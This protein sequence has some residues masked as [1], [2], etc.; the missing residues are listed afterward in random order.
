MTHDEFL[1][2]LENTKRA[3]NGHVA[4]CP[5]HEDRKQSLGV[6]QGDDGRV[7]LRCYA[8]C[9][10]EQVVT[11]MGLELKDLF[12]RPAGLGDPEAIYD[13]VDESGELVM[14]AIRFP[15]KNFRQRQ[16]IPGHAHAD[17]N[18]WVWSLGNEEKGIPFVQRVPYRLPELLE[19]IAAGRWVFITEGEKDADAII[20][21]GGAAT[22]NPGGAGKWPIEWGERYFKGANVRIVVDRDEAG[23]AGA[24]VVWG[25]LEPHA[26]RLQSVAA[27]AGKDAYDHLRAGHELGDFVAYDLHEVTDGLVLQNAQTVQLL[28][29]EWIEGYE[30]FFPFGGISMLFGHPGVN[31]STLTAHLAGIITRAKRDAIFLSNEG[32]VQEMKP[33]LYVAGAIM[34]RC[35][36]LNKLEGGHESVVTLPHD[37]AALE[38]LIEKVGA[39]LL[40][41]DPLDAALGIDVDSYKAQHVRHALT[42][43]HG[44]AQKHNMAILLVSHLNQD[45]SIDPH[46]RAGGPRLTGLARA[47]AL[48]ALSRDDENDRHLAGFKNNWGPLPKSKLMKI[49]QG[50]VPGL[51][52]PAVKLYPFS[53]TGL[54]AKHLL[55]EPKED[56]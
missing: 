34:E 37:V 38:A 8:G 10:V 28:D 44:V 49:E 30:N 2:R 27:A 41:I 36:F 39:G 7:L 24:R 21:N 14:Q 19:A 13:Y 9:S 4:R 32:G 6:H 56:R 33:R 3:G 12:D 42:P 15:D 26:A 22:C 35:H 25:S 53:T 16:R 45:K 29:R 52:E 48:M 17:D 54:K 11:A 55:M 20:A 51:E 1:S 31:K 46:R 47:C 40:V 43:L 23:K 18:G 50:H 5:A